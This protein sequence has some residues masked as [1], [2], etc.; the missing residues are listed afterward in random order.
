MKLKVKETLANILAFIKDNTIQYGYA[1]NGY[2]VK[3]SF[4]VAICWGS[5]SSNDWM[6]SINLPIAYMNAN[7]YSAVATYQATYGERETISI[8]HSSSQSFYYYAVTP[9][10]INWIAVGLWKSLGGVAHRLL[11]A[12]QSLAYRKAVVV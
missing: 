11:K 4:G 6:G 7:A 8:T 5:K 10:A 9:H 3:F 1:N 2:Y 12:L